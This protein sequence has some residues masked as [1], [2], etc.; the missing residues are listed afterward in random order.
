[1][2]RTSF[3]FLAF[4]VLTFAALPAHADDFKACSNNE[5]QD[6]NALP[7]SA[8][9]YP[10]CKAGYVGT[11]PVCYTDCPDGYSDDGVIC[12]KNAIITAKAS[13]GRGAGSPMGCG[14][15][16]EKDGALCYPACKSGL[17]RCRSGVLGPLRLRLPRRWRHLLQ[18][19]PALL[20]QRHL[21]AWRRQST[22]LLWIR[23][24]TEWTTL[25]PRLASP[26]IQASGPVCWE[27]CPSGFHDDGALCRKD[28]DIFAKSSYGRGAG[29]I[30]SS[31]NTS[32]FTKTMTSNTKQPFTMVISGDVQLPWWQIR[33][34]QQ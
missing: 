33:R 31:C 28:A 7:G 29:H 24:G 12:R 6:P 11:G 27:N 4:V 9:C 10:T 21:R 8:L 14:S 17:L 25:L 18:E 2:L 13:Y 5:M 15:G 30:P 26:G 1:M 3:G 34:R 16:K 22:Q 20:C 32:S 23:S 19:H